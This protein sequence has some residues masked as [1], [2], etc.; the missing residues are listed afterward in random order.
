MKPNQIIILLSLFNFIFLKVEEGNIYIAMF[1]NFTIKHSQNK[2]NSKSF[3]T[4]PLKIGTP[5]EIFNVQV[6]TSTAT[7]WVP[8]SNCKNCI[9]STKLYKESS[10][11]TSSPTDKEIELEDEDGDL[12]GYEISDNIILGNYKLK[13]FNFVQATKLDDDFRDYYD[14]KLGLGYKSENND[15]NFLDRLK[16]NNLIIKKIFSI[17]TINDK[18]GM[19][20]IGDLPGKQYN[21]YCNVTTD[22]DD[23]DDM[24]K[25]SWVCHLTHIGIFKINKGISNKIKYYTELENNNLVSFD[26]AYDYIAVPISEKDIIEKLIEKAHLK[27]ET[28]EKDDI[29]KLDKTSKL[30]NRI[31][32]EEISIIC[33][34]N[35]EELR[36]KGIALSFVLQGH[37]YSIPLELLFSNY[38]EDGKMEMLIRY[39]DDDDAIWILGYPFMSQFLTIFNMEDNHVGIKKLKKT[40]LPL[41]NLYKDWEIWFQNKEGLRTTS[42]AIAIIIL[43][44]IIIIIGFFVY[45]YIR[46]KMDLKNPK[47]E[48]DEENNNNNKVY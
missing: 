44:L 4:I 20:L 10:S 15:F 5:P 18:K 11:S 19:L 38:P 8:S 46:R 14:G 3:Y 37:A 31:R 32:E 35:I 28:R 22:T 26:T 6:D 39:I 1:S 47:I 48:L 24:F 16:K 21:T 34:T 40:A 23:L 29:Q 42:R 9:L 30:K 33:E 7:T 12:E 27:C 13:Q 25:E 17:S 2:L 36:M 41:V 45:R 43:I